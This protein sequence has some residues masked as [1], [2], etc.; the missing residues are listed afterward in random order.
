M[1]VL[2]TT[3]AFAPSS[4]GGTGVLVH[5]LALSLL[6]RG[7]AVLVVTGHPATTELEVGDRVDEYC[8]DS[9][10][11]VR[12]RRGRILPDQESNPMRLHY[13]NR[14]FETKFRGVLARFAPDV[15]HF[16]HLERLSVTAVDTCREQEIPAFFT[17]TDYWCVCPTHTL[18]LGDGRICNGPTHD[19]ANC[20]QHLAA[21]TT[22]TSWATR[23]LGHVPT[24]LVGVAM[25]A[26]KKA[27]ASFGGNVGYAQALAQRGDAIVARFAL[28]EKVFVPTRFLQALLDKRG[29][30]GERIR[31]LPY[32]L[33]LEGYSRRTRRR[34]DG[35]LVLGF[36]GTLQPHKGVHVLLDAVRRLPAA[37]P[38]EL[39]IYGSPPADEEPYSLELQ[40]TSSGDKRIKFLGTFDNRR[41]AQV[42]D[43]IDVLVVPSLWHENMPLVALSAQ[44]AACPLIASDVGGLAE[45][46]VHENNG[47]LFAPGSSSE[48]AE[49]IMRVLNEKDLLSGLSSRA[50]RP[51]DME[52]YVDELE[53]EYRRACE[54]SK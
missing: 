12:Y 21:A 43:G 15:V 10:S 49:L 40:T 26:L 28:L 1:K 25:S 44:A 4:A 6:K 16:H 24:R 54:R 46:V 20:L 45:V 32:G 2:L 50:A 47:L 27:D 7:H 34:I 33:R 19:A 11:V 29:I 41:I 35:P 38:I 51:L 39:R 30:S 52:C 53:S 3:H 17:A 13:L 48:L 8:V 22:R 31:V 9:I 36:I 23:A 18:L 37:S 42:L 14:S 5:E